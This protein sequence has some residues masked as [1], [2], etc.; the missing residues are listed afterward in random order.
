MMMMPPELKKTCDQAYRINETQTHYSPLP[1]S[2]H[3]HTHTETNL[4]PK[5]M[6]VLNIQNGE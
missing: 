2:V 3:A 4:E 5:Y 1:A 6:A